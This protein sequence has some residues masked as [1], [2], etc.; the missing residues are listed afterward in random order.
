VAIE[1]GESGRQ[2][3]V[4]QRSGPGDFFV[5]HRRWDHAGGDGKVSLQVG[6]GQVSFIGLLRRE[7]LKVGTTIHFCVL[8]FVLK[9][10]H[11]LDIF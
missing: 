4:V 10:I 11:F 7:F 1:C 2:Q 3:F 8:D 9:K 5:E 6:C